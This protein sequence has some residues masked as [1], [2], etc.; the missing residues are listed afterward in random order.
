MMFGHK[1]LKFAIGITWESTKNSELEE[2]LFLT[3]TREKGV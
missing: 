3:K 1:V 2:I